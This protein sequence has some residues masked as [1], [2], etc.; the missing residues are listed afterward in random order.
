MSDKNSQNL[1]HYVKSNLFHIAFERKIYEYSLQVV[2][3]GSAMPQNQNTSQMI[4]ETLVEE[5]EPS[6]A[7]L[8]EI[9]NALNLQFSAKMPLKLFDRTSGLLFT[10]FFVM[11]IFMSVSIPVLVTSQA[12]STNSDNKAGG[13]YNVSFKYKGL[14]ENHEILLTKLWKGF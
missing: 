6:E 9:E 2:P 3:Q 1:H 5:L 4:E 12:T 7:L 14:L 13:T 11:D 10:P 8:D